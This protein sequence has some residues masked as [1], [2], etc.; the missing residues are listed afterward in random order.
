M[1]YSIRQSG[2][3][4]VNCI[5]EL[6][7]LSQYF[8]F[9]DTLERML[10]D[11]IV[12]HISNTQTQKCLRA[13]KNLMFAKAKEIVFALESAVQDTRVIQTS[14]SDTVHKVADSNKPNSYK[15]YQCGKTNHSMLT[16]VK[17]MYQ[18]RPLG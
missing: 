14:S 3:S 17:H 15:C 9:R 8:N 1:Q 2:E 10:R 4:V 13:E 6:Q 11:R 7:A 16:H 5:A 12:F 18:N